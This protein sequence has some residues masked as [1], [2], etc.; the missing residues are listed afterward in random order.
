MYKRQVLAKASAG[1]SLEP[2]RIAWPQPQPVPVDFLMTGTKQDL[3]SFKDR[4]V[5]LVT[6][7]AVSYT[8]LDVYKRQASC[9]GRARRPGPR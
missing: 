8:H 9:H 5:I 3:L 4:A 1:L 2:A 6:V 7:N